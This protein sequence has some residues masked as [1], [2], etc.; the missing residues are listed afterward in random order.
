VYSAGREETEKILA[1]FRDLENWMKRDDGL[2]LWMEEWEKGY[3]RPFERDVDCVEGMKWIEHVESGHGC[4]PM[5]QSGWAGGRMNGSNTIAE[6]PA[7]NGIN[8]QHN[9]Q[10]KSINTTSGGVT[11][12][13]STTTGGSDSNGAHNQYAVQHAVQHTPQQNSQ[14][15]SQGNDSENNTGFEVCKSVVAWLGL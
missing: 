3:G 6:G 13:N 15:N 8:A 2:R 10:I 4:V 11:A 9:G 1:V 14:G 7:S 5:R 12:V